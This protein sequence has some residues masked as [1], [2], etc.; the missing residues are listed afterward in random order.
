MSAG[1]YSGFYGYN[2][3]TNKQIYHQ[4]KENYP[5]LVSDNNK[6]FLWRGRVENDPFSYIIT[7]IESE[8]PIK[9]IK[10]DKP[11]MA[12]F[13]NINSNN[14]FICRYRL[15]GNPSISAINSLISLNTGSNQPEFEL[16]GWF[17]SIKAGYTTDEEHYYKCRINKK[18]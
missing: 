16:N 7:D 13:F 5:T 10:F 15:S 18:D 12:I 14:N 3:Q 9:K 2:M 1:N 4:S 11:A 6:Y 17:Y 8:I